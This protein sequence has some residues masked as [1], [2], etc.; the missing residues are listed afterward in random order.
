MGGPWRRMSEREMFT[1]E[2][3]KKAEAELAEAKEV[4]ASHEDEQDFLRR[5]VENVY[6]WAMESPNYLMAKDADALVAATRKGMTPE[7]AAM[8]RADRAAE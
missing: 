7:Q 5:L 1:Q 4:I 3:A 6:S 8:W 2:R